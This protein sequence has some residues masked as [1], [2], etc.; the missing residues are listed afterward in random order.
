MMMKNSD[1][2]DIS[3]TSSTT[4]AVSSR[5]P[6]NIASP[7]ENTIDTPTVRMN[8]GTPMPNEIGSRSRISSAMSRPSLVL[9]KSKRSSRML[10]ST[11]TVSV[12]L[13]RP[14]AFALK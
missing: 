8:T 12:S 13:E 4:P 10:V 1:E 9:P 3:A 6:R 11:K 2:I 7:S 14:G 5:E